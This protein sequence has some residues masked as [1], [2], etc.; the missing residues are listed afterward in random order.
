[1]EVLPS[2][3]YLLGRRKQHGRT[4]MP[5]GHSPNI[6]STES[7]VIEVHKTVEFICKESG[8]M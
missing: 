8:L 1:M 3:R 7:Y 5:K 2:V 4:G 6:P